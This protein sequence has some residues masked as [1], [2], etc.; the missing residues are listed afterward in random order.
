MDSGKNEGGDIKGEGLECAE[1]DFLELRFDDGAHKKAAPKKFLG[2]RDDEDRA[3]SAK[4]DGENSRNKAYLE[5][6]GERESVVPFS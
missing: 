2:D 3:Q 1:G 4:K 6:G 5:G